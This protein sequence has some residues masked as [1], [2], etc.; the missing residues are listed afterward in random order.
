M[1]KG[2]SNKAT[3]YLKGLDAFTIPLSEV[4]DPKT[5]E[6]IESAV[7]EIDKI[8]PADLS[9]TMLGIAG[10]RA[11]NADS[12]GDQFVNVGGML[13]LVGTEVGTPTAR[14]I[15]YH[16]VTHSI[17]GIQNTG[18]TSAQF[19]KDRDREYGNKG[20]RS[21][22]EDNPAYSEEEKSYWDRFTNPY[23]GKVYEADPD[24]GSKANSEVV[25]MAIQRLAGPRPLADLTNRDREQ[26]MYAL[27]VL[28]KR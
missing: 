13:G 19:I 11:F 25:T 12:D 27:S 24:M 23:V 3:E 18:E 28:S 21:L 22:S 7:A 17:E 6:I 16:E 8:T 5:V 4:Y 20:L 15:I 9:S 10:E 26:L 2:D 1:E 14:A